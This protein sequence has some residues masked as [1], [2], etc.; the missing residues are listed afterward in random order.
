MSSVEP[1]LSSIVYTGVLN[2][3]PSQ[4]G[5]ENEVA[6]S[7]MLSILALYN[8]GIYTSQECADEVVVRLGRSMTTEES[9][10]L[11]AFEQYVA[12][13]NSDAIDRLQKCRLGFEAV[14]RNFG[15][16][17]AQVRQLIGI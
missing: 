1:P 6:V 4:N 14:E 13:T 10:D 8:A 7:D 5:A 16:T 3:I 15:L 9:S 17:D 11:V 2:L 12:S